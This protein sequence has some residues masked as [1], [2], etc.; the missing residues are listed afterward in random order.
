[1]PLQPGQRLGPY[2]IL[3]AIGAGGMG[4]VYKA[5]DTRLDRFVALKILAPD[6]VAN[7]ERKRRF[8][9]EAKSAST[10]NHPNIITIYDIGREGD[11]DYIAMEYV[12]GRTL[13]SLIGQ[14]GLR[15]NEALKYAAQMAD[16]LSAA[17]AA[18]I[19][20]RD[21]KPANVRVNDAGLVK[22]LDFGL[23][24]LTDRSET[25]EHDAP[26]PRVLWMAQF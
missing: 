13:D 7:P 25:T 22:V 5:R 11:V 6:V 18:G 16:A 1:M 10:L 26:G 3:A 17:H 24:K 4:E 20:H 19:L 15:I 2:E 12:Q 21:L 9:Q 8:S 23:A 14:A